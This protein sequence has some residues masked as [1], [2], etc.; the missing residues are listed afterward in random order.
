[1]EK[2]KIYL[3]QGNY[4][5]DMLKLFTIVALISLWSCNNA[6]KNQTTNKTTADIERIHTDLDKLIN[7]DADLEVIAEGFT[8][9]EGPLW[10]EEAKML[11]FS[12]IPPNKVFKWTEQGGLALYLEPAG[13]TS[14]QVRGGE[15]G[16]NGLLLDRHKNLVLCQHGDRRIARM[17]ALLSH[18][19][20]KFITLAAKW[21]GKKLNSPNDI[22]ERSN[23]DLFFTDPIYGLNDQHIEKQEL[24]FCGV[25]KIDTLGR[26]SLLIDTIN[27]PNGIALSPN[28][29]R[30]YIGN[31]DDQKPMLYAFDITPDDSLKSAGIVFDFSKFGGGP[32]GFKVDKEGNIFA[33]GPGGIWIFNSSYQLIG[34]IRIKQRVSN[35]CLADDDK[36][37]YITA[38]NQ[39]LR[40]RM[41]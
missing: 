12:D 3:E 21:K 34:K 2:K 31:S 41:R 9:V 15:I 7:I 20:S 22:V 10:V 37:L 27:R 8:W 36:T 33:S 23:G 35:C 11:L 14:N 6:V 25:Y 38:S 19:E 13:Y 5:K 4:K 28:E 17:D 40:L 1:M 24:D 30:L 39:V 29:N 26:L 16:S 18:P 32:D